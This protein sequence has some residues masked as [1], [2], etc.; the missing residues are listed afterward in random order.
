MWDKRVDLRRVTYVDLYTTNFRY[1]VGNHYDVNDYT[2]VQANE[3]DCY[4]AEIR[5]KF[6][7]MLLIQPI[8]GHDVTCVM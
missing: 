4:Y 1:T 2:G 8:E 3:V 7:T 6:N 5:I